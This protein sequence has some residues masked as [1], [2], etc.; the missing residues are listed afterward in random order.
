MYK[1]DPAL[2]AKPA[3]PPSFPSHHSLFPVP[4]PINAQVQHQMDPNV[5][6]QPRY[7]STC[8]PS[9]MP[10]GVDPTSVD[11]R[12]FFPYIPNEVK[13]RKR[14]SRHQLKV[15]EDVF[16]KDTKPNAV[17]RKKLAAELEMSPR[18]VQV[19]SLSPRRR[20]L[21]LRVAPPSG[22][23]PEQVPFNLS[24]PLSSDVPPPDVPRKRLCVNAFLQT[25]T[26]LR[27]R[28]CLRRLETPPPTTLPTRLPPQRRQD[29][30]RNMT[31]HRVYPLW[32]HLLAPWSRSP[33]HPRPC[34]NQRGRASQARLLIFR[35]TS[36][37]SIQAA[38][39]LIYTA[40]DEVPC[41][42]CPHSRTRD[43]I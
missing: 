20:V 42:S 4:V 21:T 8:I 13:H 38:R 16:R 27:R 2:S 15:L 11:F 26:N 41:R 22:L 6:P 5:L 23:V 25:P 9:L 7:P 28:K 18:A 36:K 34:S 3:T 29:V 30:I 39:T 33:A 32:S 35:L 10:P 40:R 14:T 31:S 37:H 17:L 1:T 24:L 43:Q 12:T 19:R